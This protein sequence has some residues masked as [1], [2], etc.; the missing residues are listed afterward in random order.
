MKLRPFELILVVLFAGL[1]FLA[2]V[3]LASYKGIVGD[4]APV[5]GAVTIWGTL[6]SGPI[7]QILKEIKDSNEDYKDVTYYYVGANDFSQTLTNALVDGTGPDVILI[8]HEQL[9]ELRKRI[10]AFSYEYFPE[11]DVRNTYIDGADIFALNDG[12][13]AYPVAVDPI[14]LYWNRDLLTGKGFLSA[15]TTWEDLVNVQFPTLIDRGFDRSINRG[16]VAMGEYENIRNSFGLLSALLIQS[17]SK[18]VVEEGV[19]YQILLDQ[20]SVNGGRPLYNALDFYTRFSR[21]NNILYSWNRSFE[22]DRSEFIAE[23]LSFYFGY[24]SEAKAIEQLNPNLSFDI[25]EIPQG[26][27]ATVRRTYGNFYG[28]SL[29]K[30]TKNQA[31]ALKVM[32]LL[33][34]QTNAAWIAI[35]YGMAPAHRSLV[36]AGSND[37]YGRIIYKSAPIAYG[38]LNPPRHNVDPIFTSMTRDVNENR[39]EAGAASQ[40]AV[41]RLKDAY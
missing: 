18:G 31:G 19:E 29:V 24:G 32:A 38:W 9:V 11:R 22:E 20:S 10:S 33:G 16:V 34:N 17:G 21:V 1:G 6:D 14:M 28:L 15:P 4:E 2:L 39:Y 35:E 5:V 27:A 30:N 37:T 26:A 7:N 13:Y 23:D 8:S 40:D 3:L 36:S 12:M 25:A 41:S